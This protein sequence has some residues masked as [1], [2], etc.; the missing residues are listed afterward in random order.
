[1]ICAADTTD[2]LVDWLI[3][4]NVNGSDG[5]FYPDSGKWAELPGKGPFR[6]KAT[7]YHEGE[8]RSEN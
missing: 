7:T 1:M 5:C 2:P 6:L 3:G 8:E 4:N